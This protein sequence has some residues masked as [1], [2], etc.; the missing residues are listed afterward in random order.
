MNSGNRGI[1]WV[2]PNPRRAAA[3][4]PYSPF[5]TLH[6][7]RVP[8]WA[9]SKEVGWHETCKLDRGASDSVRVVFM[10]ETPPKRKTGMKLIRKSAQGS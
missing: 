1:S 8:V 6:G 3:N 5:G 2:V 4:L 10:P 9:G 7:V